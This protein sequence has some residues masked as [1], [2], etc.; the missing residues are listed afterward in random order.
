MKKR[1]LA[2]LLALS[3]LVSMV[4]TAFA[5]DDGTVTTAAE[6]TA[7]LANGGN[8]TLGADITDANVQ[9]QFTK[10]TVLDLNGHTVSGTG[11]SSGYMFRVVNS[12][13]VTIKNGTI[14]NTKSAGRCV[15][16]R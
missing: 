11:D 12:S 13:T 2:L 9:F 3:M 5:A 14:V 6:L 10:D 1:L 7:A 15:E 4:P 16:T 8:I